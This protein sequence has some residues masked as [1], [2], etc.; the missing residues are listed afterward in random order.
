MLNNLRHPSAQQNVIWLQRRQKVNPS[1]L[2][3]Q[4]S[5]SRPY[6]SKAHRIAVLRIENLLRN[7][8]QMTRIDIHSLSGEQG[9]AV[10]YCSMNKS[11]VY[12]TYSPNHAVQIWYDH[13]GNCE[14]CNEFNQ[15]YSILSELADEWQIDFPRKLSPTEMAAYLFRSISKRLGWI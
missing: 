7:A 12:I 14:S 9:F 13:S 2:A 3:D 1:H 8:A 15:C 6:I 10:G 4:M 11:K 5:V